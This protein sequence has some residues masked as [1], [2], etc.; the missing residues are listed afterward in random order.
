MRFIAITLILAMC[1]SQVSAQYPLSLVE[2]AACAQSA[3]HIEELEE[4]NKKLY[5]ELGDIQAANN[6]KTQAQANALLLHYERMV[7]YRQGLISDYELSCARGTMKYSELRKVCRPQSSGKSFEDTV[8][9]K[10]LKGD[11]K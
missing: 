5:D 10:P 8:F 1:S 7:A 3:A 6:G 2:G 11:A 4:Y 9:C